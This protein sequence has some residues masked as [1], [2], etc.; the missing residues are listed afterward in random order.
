LI[1]TPA[2]KT[3]FDV[4]DLIPSSVDETERMKFYDVSGIIQIENLNDYVRYSSIKCID[5]S[6][7]YRDYGNMHLYTV[8][9]DGDTE[10]LNEYH[11]ELIITNPS[12][13]VE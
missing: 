3:L 11:D 12:L 2:N 4:S 9:L 8:E 6:V 7:E 13:V 1:S 10:R 5:V